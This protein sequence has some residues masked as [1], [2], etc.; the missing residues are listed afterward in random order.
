MDFSI[1]KK[2]G[3]GQL[4]FGNLCEVSRVTVSNW[5]LG[6]TAPNRHV[7][8][9]VAKQLTLLR[10]AVRLRYLPGDIPTMHKNNV[11]A[12]DEFIRDMLADAAE[13]LREQKAKRAKK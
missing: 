2:A 11:G 6:K 3:I 5:V 13:K 4:E 7:V 8:K 12:R 1:I 9:Q 10:A